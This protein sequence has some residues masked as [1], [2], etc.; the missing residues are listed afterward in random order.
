MKVLKQTVH[1][2][3]V[4]VGTQVFHTQPELEAFLHRFAEA[5]KTFDPDRKSLP[6]TLRMLRE[7]I[8]ISES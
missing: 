6:A 2:L 4:L 1:L 3:K 5:E 8:P 7:G